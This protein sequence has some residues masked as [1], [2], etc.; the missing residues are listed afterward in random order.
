MARHFPPY[1][2]GCLTAAPL[3]AL[4]IK[5]GCPPALPVRRGADHQSVISAGYA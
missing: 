4:W 5:A 3:G 2:P 1:V